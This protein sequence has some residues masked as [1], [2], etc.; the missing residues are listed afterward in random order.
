MY[1][2]HTV[3]NIF[4][5]TGNISY[6]IMN[7]SAQLWYYFTCQLTD[8]IDDGLKSELIIKSFIWIF[9][10]IGVYFVRYIGVYHRIV[11]REGWE[12]VAWGGSEGLTLEFVRRKKKRKE[13]LI[14]EINSASIMARKWSPAKNKIH[15]H[16]IFH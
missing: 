13:I 9:I 6:I 8:S 10:F 16:R 1:L 2:F 15:F 11:G 7:I 4:N 3:V 14:F 12:R 5:I